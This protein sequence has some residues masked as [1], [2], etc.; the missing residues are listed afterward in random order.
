LAIEFVTAEKSRLSRPARRD[1]FRGEVRRAT[2]QEKTMNGKES[3]TEVMMVV[4]FHRRTFVL[5]SVIVRVAREFT[6]NAS[7]S[8]PKRATNERNGRSRMFI[9][10]ELIRVNKQ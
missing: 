5:L 8:L 1:I 6:A 4:L 3:D 9:M 2:D 7:P 10:V